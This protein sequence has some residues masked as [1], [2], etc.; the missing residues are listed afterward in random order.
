MF[1]PAIHEFTK[2][3]PDRPYDVERRRFVS[4]N[5]QKI[6]VYV[7]FKDKD[8]YDVFTDTELPVDADVYERVLALST[9]DTNMSAHEYFRDYI[10]DVAKAVYVD[11]DY[12]PVLV[13]RIILDEHRTS[14]VFELEGL[15]C[16]TEY[17]N[18]STSLT[19][20]LLSEFF[21]TI[22]DYPLGSVF[23]FSF[24]TGFRVRHS[25][26][27]IREFFESKLGAVYGPFEIGTDFVQELLESMGPI[28]RPAPF[29]NPKF[30]MSHD[31]LAFFYDEYAWY[32][33]ELMIELVRSRLMI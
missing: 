4:G 22:A 26:L 21:R 13:R 1:F 27:S 11:G 16:I 7:C 30:S 2:T 15:E 31:E 5:N 23:E 3:T 19:T 6:N 8:R 9:V 33:E 29:A 25:R 20:V 28:T 12:S 10:A 32:D 24:R 17:Q 18:T 14:V